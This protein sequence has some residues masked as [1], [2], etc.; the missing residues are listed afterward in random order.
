M[1]QEAVNNDVTTEVESTNESNELD[2]PSNEQQDEQKSYD[3]VVEENERLKQNLRNQAKKRRQLDGEDG[4][5]EQDDDSSEYVNE[6]E[7]RLARLE[8]AQQSK[9]NDYLDGSLD[10]LYDQSWGKKYAPETPG[11][12]R[13]FA[14]FQKELKRL[15][16]E[17]EVTS[18]EEYFNLMRLADVNVTGS[19]DALMDQ[20]SQRK[21]EA[22]QA[23]ASMASGP[24]GSTNYTPKN[25]LSSEA[26]KFLDAYGVPEEKRRELS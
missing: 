8:Q 14:Q 13:K 9:L 5:G 21:R 4:D 6:L 19:P 25:S 24:S 18:K 22:N 11:S 26:N 23:L 1:D 17:R 10:D 2:S 7:E 12:E 16:S 3:Q 20:R 15:T